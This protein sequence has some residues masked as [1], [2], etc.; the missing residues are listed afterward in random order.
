[1]EWMSTNLL[2]LS[3][4]DSGIFPLD[5][6]DG[7][8]RDPV[9]AVVEA[10]AE[11]AEQRGV[12][13]SFEVPTSPIMLPFDRE[14][15]VQLLNN[16]VANALKFT[17]SGGEVV[18][19]A[20]DV[21]DAAV[22]EVRDSGP[23]ISPDELPHIFDRFFRGTNVGEARASGSG[24]GLAIT[25]SLAEM[26]GGRIDVTSAPGRGSIFS[27]RLPRDGSEGQ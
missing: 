11:Q 22:V 27:V 19:D 26:H 9:R 3:R 14:R 12:S 13:L 25:R 8:L 1:M 16:L 4:M 10:H 5:V 20:Q 15:I 18:V 17:P 6:R 24:L 21:G 2:D 23:G 7:D